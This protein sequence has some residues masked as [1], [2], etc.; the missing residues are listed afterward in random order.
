MGNP[1]KAVVSLVKNVA[2]QVKF[3]PLTFDPW[4]FIIKLAI[5]LAIQ[6]AFQKI[7]G[8]KKPSLPSPAFEVENETSKT[9]VRSPV[10]NR[11]IMYGETMTSGP[12]VYASTSGTDNKFLHL[13]IPVS[14][15]D[16]A[17]GIQSIDKIYLND[18]TIT[19]SSDLDGSNVVNTGTYD[20]KVRVKTHLGRSTQTAD[21]DLVSDISDWGS[22]H[23]G[24]SIAYVY[25]RLEYNQ[26][27]FPTGIPNVRVQLKGAKVKDTRYTNFAAN[28]VINT[29][30][31]V[32]TISSHGLSTGD[33]WI[34]NNN[35]N[36]N[37]N[38]Q[39]RR[40]Q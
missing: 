5:T 1:V 20:G 36:S 25:L 34:Y 2:N 21:S 8:R 19:L 13:V 3:G 11:T 15:T 10:A 18:K 35:S 17:Y 28:S 23:I 6:Y 38:A 4:T 31:E 32:F 16:N 29:S 12:I 40:E 9:M 14:L 7:S 30:T 22:N 26:D 27:T 33:G 37:N 24:K 39:R